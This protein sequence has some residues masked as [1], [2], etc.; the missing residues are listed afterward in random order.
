M[1]ESRRRRASTQKRPN[2]PGQAKAA[3]A[4]LKLTVRPD[5][6]PGPDVPTVTAE[7]TAGSPKPETKASAY[8]NGYALTLELGKRDKGKVPGKIYLSLP[9]DAKD[10][11]AGT[12]AAEPEASVI[13]RVADFSSPSL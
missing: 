13:V 10:F 4:G 3:S 12:F 6:P 2:S 8:V 1:L 9:T 7:V 5:Q 11:L